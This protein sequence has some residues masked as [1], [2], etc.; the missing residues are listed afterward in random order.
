VTLPQLDKRFCESSLLPEHVPPVAV[1]LCGVGPEADRL[2]VCGDCI[3]K[4]PL[5][6]EGV[7]KAMVGQNVLCFQVDRDAVLL[8]RLVQ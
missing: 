7:A 5:I 4:P 1:G 6:A 8:D 2:A 3:L